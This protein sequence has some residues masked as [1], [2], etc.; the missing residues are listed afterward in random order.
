MS[1]LSLGAQGELRCGRAAWPKP[2]T[3]RRSAPLHTQEHCLFLKQLSDA[4]RFREQLGYAF[5]QAGLG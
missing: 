4:V 5:E 2:P 1:P 3:L